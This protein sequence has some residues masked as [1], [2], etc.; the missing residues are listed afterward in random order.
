MDVPDKAS[1][2]HD[3]EEKHI[4]KVRSEL[5]SFFS[6]GSTPVLVP[7]PRMTVSRSCRTRIQPERTLNEGSAAAVR[8][9]HP[10]AAAVASRNHITPFFTLFHAHT[11]RPFAVR[12]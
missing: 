4:E 1:E 9:D 8:R 6:A 11:R 2:L 10:A 3:V 7:A 12:A 5:C